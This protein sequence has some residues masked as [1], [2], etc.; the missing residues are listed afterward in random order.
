MLQFPAVRKLLVW[1]VFFY[2]PVIITTDSF[3]ETPSFDGQAFNYG[4][5]AAETVTKIIDH[6][7]VSKSQLSMLQSPLGVAHNYVYMVNIETVSEHDGMY[8]PLQTV[9]RQGVQRETGEWDWNSAVIDDRTVYDPWHTPP[10]VGIDRDGFIHV[11]YNMHNTPWQYKVSKNPHDISDFDFKGQSISD[12]EIDSWQY[13]NK[14]S[15]P[16]L[17]TG[18]IPGNQITYPSFSNDS[19][20]NLYVSYRFASKPKRTFSQRAMSAGV[21]KY[22]ADTKT[23]SAIG[24]DVWVDENDRNYISNAPNQPKPFAV[25]QHWTVSAPQLAFG[26]S[27]EVYA[28][29][30]WRKGTAGALYTRPCIVRA[31][32]FSA[33]IRNDNSTQNLPLTVDSCGNLGFDDYQ[34]FYSLNKIDTNSQAT[35]SLLLHQSTNQRFLM[36]RQSGSQQWVRQAAPAGA[37]DIFYDRSDNLWAVGRGLTVYKKPYYSDQWSKVFEER[38]SSNDCYPKVVMNESKNRAYIHTHACDEKSI[39]L[40]LLQLD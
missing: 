17:G 4:G 19:E 14:T 18:A 32:Q 15:F 13:E 31:S 25:E 27:N 5:Y 29:F 10:A 26:P 36:Q 7:R 28:S 33:Y 1:L 37:T 11:A 12:R 8:A 2:S 38:G 22:D 35:V 39:S 24:G 30:M 40:Y 23:W 21:A 3:A 34:T 16:N 9:L 20:R 6:Q